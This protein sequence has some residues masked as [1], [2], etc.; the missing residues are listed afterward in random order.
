MPRVTEEHRQAR[1]RQI[2]LAA[3]RAFG[4][5][6]L[7]STSMADVIAESQ[8]SA[9]AVY[10]YFKSKDELI[11]AV[12]REVLS[13]VVARLDDLAAADEPRSPVAIVGGLLDRA[14]DTREPSPMR[15]LPLLM[16]VWSESAYSG[17]VADLAISWV[18]ELRAGVTMLLRRWVDAGHTLPADPEQFAPVLIAMVQGF[19]VQAA[20][21]STQS[22]PDY[23]AAALTL[24]AAAGLDD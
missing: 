5:S 15:S 12:A 14:A 23:R 7:Q 20:L 8:M 22:P 10:L 11:E 2:L 6:G 9:G 17:P 24:L 4:R 21:G 1:R 13:G 18:G 3:M 16:G 19:I